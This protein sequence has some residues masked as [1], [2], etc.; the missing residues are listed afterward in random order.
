MIEILKFPSGAR[1]FSICRKYG[2]VVDT[3]NI[4]VDTSDTCRVLGFLIGVIE[5]L[6]GV[7]SFW[8]VRC[9]NLVLVVL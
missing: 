4:V 2:I 3:S 5:F 1:I 8:E 9:E 7:I 6:I